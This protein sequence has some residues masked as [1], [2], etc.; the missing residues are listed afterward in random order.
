M[1]VK[2]SHRE[3]SFSALTLNHHSAP[4]WLF[5]QARV[6]G[7]Q[8]N[9]LVLL[10]L[11]GAGTNGYLVIPPP[12]TVATVAASQPYIIDKFIFPIQFSI[13][14]AHRLTWHH[15]HRIPMLITGAWRG[16]AAWQCYIVTAAQQSAGNKE[17]AC[18]GALS[19]PAAGGGRAGN[20]K[21]SR[22]DV[23]TLSEYQIWRTN[24]QYPRQVVTASRKTKHCL[25]IAQSLLCKA[26]A[27]TFV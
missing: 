19:L 22:Y 12:A 16:H 8:R 15:G 9:F 3:G 23:I 18:T 13:L 4:D 7:S 26:K 27:N 21:W 20:I 1:I 14:S 17:V 6:L 2:S 24:F 5:V 11:F 10:I 25:V